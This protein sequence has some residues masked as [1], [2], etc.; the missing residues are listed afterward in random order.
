MFFSI[1]WEKIKDGSQGATLSLGS[2]G[3]VGT[4]PSYLVTDGTLTDACKT[5][6]VDNVPHVSI[7]QV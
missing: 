6:L 7:S 4:K 5:Q 1:D 2:K 3:I